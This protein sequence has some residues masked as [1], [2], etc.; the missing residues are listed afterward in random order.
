VLAAAVGLKSLNSAVIPRNAEQVLA[1]VC[2]AD[3]GASR[4]ELKSF[5]RRVLLVVENARKLRRTHDFQT[6][7]GDACLIGARGGFAGEPLDCAAWRQLVSGR[8]RVIEVAAPHEAVV[9]APFA[10]VVGAILEDAMR[11]ERPKEA[12]HDRG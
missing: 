1:M 11:T 2:D 4:P 12:C 5:L 6:Y 7:E 3:D 9:F 10:K 8:V